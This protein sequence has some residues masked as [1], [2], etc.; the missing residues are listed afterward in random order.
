MTTVHIIT[1]HRSIYQVATSA[2]HSQTATK[3]LSENKYAKP[4]QCWQQ[5]QLVL[6]TRPF[7]EGTLYSIL[8]CYRLVEC[9]IGFRAWPQAVGR[10]VSGR[11]ATNL[12]HTRILQGRYNRLGPKLVEQCLQVSKSIS[13]TW[14]PAR[15][16]STGST[17]RTLP[18]QRL[19]ACQKQAC[20]LNL[21]LTQQCQIASW[22]SPGCLHDTVHSAHMF[23]KVPS[24]DEKAGGSRLNVCLSMLHSMQGS[25]SILQKCSGSQLVV[26]AA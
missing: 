16:L 25:P 5:A 24:S 21:F 23:H 7:K 8:Q 1:R 9:D 12:C 10:Q 15:R 26:Y 14:H 17:A 6:S 20:L 18:V 19:L 2:I 22:E 4:G 3:T 13:N 11:M